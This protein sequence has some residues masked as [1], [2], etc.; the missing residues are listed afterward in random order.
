MKR[1]LTGLKPVRCYLGVRR[2]SG[3]Q[4]VNSL[5]LP[6]GGAQVVSMNGLFLVL[7]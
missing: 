7:I 1:L 3:I 2:A 5:R 6:E 4:P